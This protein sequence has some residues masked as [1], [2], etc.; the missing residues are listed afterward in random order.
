MSIA[1]RLGPKGEDGS[2]V[3]EFLAGTL[4]LLIPIVYLILTFASV[5]AATYAAEAAARESGRIYARADTIDE[6]EHRSRAAT[7][8]AFADHGF[9]SGTHRLTVTCEATPCLT[10]GAGVHVTIAI[11][12]PLPLIP[13]FIARAVPTSVRVSA[14]AFATIDRFRP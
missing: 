8:L 1:P 9:D 7:H 3:V 4:L 14:D 11:D 10:P 6:A 13:D 12:V 5:Q 2:A